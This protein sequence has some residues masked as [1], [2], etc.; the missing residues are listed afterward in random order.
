MVLHP[1]TA[2]NAQI[3]ACKKVPGDVKLKM[4]AV[5]IEAAEKKYTKKKRETDAFETVDGLVSAA[6]AKFLAKRSRPSASTR[7]SVGQSGIA[8]AFARQGAIG[9]A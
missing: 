5:L 8:M 7:K 2:K 9:A 6:A 1:A 4:S 3:A